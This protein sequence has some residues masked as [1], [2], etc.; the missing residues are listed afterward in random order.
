MK[1]SRLLLDG[2]KQELQRTLDSNFGKFGLVVTDCQEATVECDGQKMIASTDS[3]ERWKSELTIELLKEY[4]YDILRDPPPLLA[5]KNY[6][7]PRS[8]RGEIT[9]WKNQGTIIGRV[10]YVRGIY[11]TFPESLRNW[12]GRPFGAG[13]NNI[14]TMMA[15]ISLFGVVASALSIEFVL[16]RKRLR[17][18]REESE[19]RLLENESE[20]LKRELE[21]RS[22]QISALIKSEQSLLTRLQDYASR[23]RERE[24]RL[25]QELNS[26]ENE[27]GTS[28]ELLSERERELEIIRQSLRETERTIEE[29]RQSISVHEAEKES[30]KRD[31]KRTEQEY[32]DKVNAIREK[33][34]ENVNFYRIYAEDVDRNSSNLRREKERLQSENERLQS[35]NERLQSENESLRGER[36]EFDPDSTTAR[37]GIDMSSITLVLAGGGSSMRLKIISTLKQDYNLKEA[38]EIPSSDERRLDKRTIKRTARRGDLI[39]VI[40]RLTGHDLS[41]PIAQL[42]RQRAISG[43]VLMLQ[44]PGVPSAVNEI[45]NYLARQNDEPLVR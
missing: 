10:Y 24:S 11:P 1:L 23:Q 14:Y 45:V 31:L 27:V 28:R 34:K 35:E 16:Y 5:E 2:N 12:L 40:T 36:A 19:K 38:I 29:Q 20:K 9:G 7:S 42:K 8:D 13:T 44:S 18:E 25:Q 4:D 22:N 15:L 43:K 41:E 32:I 33:T 6:R 39:V 26:L 30:V 37:T 3:K 21:E 17:L